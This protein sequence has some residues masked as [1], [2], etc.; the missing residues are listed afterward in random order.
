MPQVYADT[1]AIQVWGGEDNNPPRYGQVYIAIKTKYGIN[2]TQAQK[3]SIVKLLDGY[4]IASVRPTIVDPET[5]KLRLSTTV[6]FDSK[7][8]T[9]TATSIET[10]V[11]SVL[12]SYNVSDLE[13]FDGVFRF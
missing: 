6:K 10:V 13:Q 2:L 11:D 4:N 1:K 3:D 7:S 9:K 5:I 12:S 8:T